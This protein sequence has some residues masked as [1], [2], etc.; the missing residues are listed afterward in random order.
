MFPHARFA[1]PVDVFQFETLFQLARFIQMF[2]RMAGRPPARK[3]CLKSGTHPAC[4]RSQVDIIGIYVTLR[5]LASRTKISHSAYFDYPQVCL[6]RYLFA[7][8]FA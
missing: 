3:S 4:R 5:P 8:T 6:C 1:V 2:K 7:F